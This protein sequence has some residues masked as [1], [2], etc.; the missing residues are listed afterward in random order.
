METSDF[1]L[2]HVV[3]AVVF[4]AFL[5]QRREEGENK[6]ARPEE[7]NGLEDQKKY[8]KSKQKQTSEPFP[9][10]LQVDLIRLKTIK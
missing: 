6:P 8:Q 4:L 1:D 10:S 7:K 2:L 3:L 9:T 5:A